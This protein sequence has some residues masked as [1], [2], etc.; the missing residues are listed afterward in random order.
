MNKK[1]KF[2]GF[3]YLFI[4]MILMIITIIFVLGR[5]PKT[6]SAIEI[7]ADEC[8]SDAACPTDKWYEDVTINQF[9]S[10]DACNHVQQW[11][12]EFRNYS[13]EA[14]LC[15]FEVMATGWVNAS[16]TPKPNNPS[17][18]DT[19]ACTVND[20][21]YNGECRG[22]SDCGDYSVDIGSC[23]DE[24]DNNSLTY[25]EYNYISVCSKPLDRCTLAPSNYLSE[26]IH[27]C[28]LLD[29]GAECSTDSDCD[30]GDPAFI[31][32]CL[33][34]CSCQKTKDCIDS[35]NDGYFI[36]GGSCGDK[37]CNDGDKD[38]H[39]GAL[40]I[41]NLIDDDC[42]NLTDDNATCIE[43]YGGIEL[44]DTLDNN[45]DGRIDDDCIEATKCSVS[46]N[47][48]ALES[49]DY[50]LCI[51]L[52][53]PSGFNPINHRCINPNFVPRNDSII[54][55]EC[56]PTWSCSPW[57]NCQDSARSRICTDTN[58]CDSNE[59]KPIESD[60]CESIIEDPIIVEGDKP[61]PIEPDPEII[62]EDP[63]IISEENEDST[64]KFNP[65]LWLIPLGIG[66]VIIPLMVVFM[67]KHAPTKA[68]EK[69]SEQKAESAQSFDEHRLI[70]TVEW[71]KSRG[72]TPGYVY[73]ALRNMKVTDTH[74]RWAIDKIYY[75]K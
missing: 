21:C 58:F 1:S 50:G 49:C 53:C 73:H 54:E 29:C 40:E 37:D 67:L 74:A 32:E 27:T 57:S 43:M 75:K 63:E 26:I 13:C 52:T 36:N 11:H 61:A 56:I 68:K 3:L 7:A 31:Y 48:T 55:P 70:Y 28:S 15:E 17:C 39:P 30:E 25:D 51:N 9:I 47:C 35:D 8:Q 4:F 24:S 65:L 2:Y 71:Y 69:I 45:C 66:I 38:I 12:K 59:G 60:A 44:C 10:V 5:L 64:D 23:D 19:I 22:F 18:D 34:N 16:P 41:I 6:G 46:Q 62:P 33:D 42:N 72:M 20:T 14:G